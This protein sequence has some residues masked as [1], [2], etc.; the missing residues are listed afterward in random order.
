MFIS[1]I[2]LSTNPPTLYAHLRNMYIN[3]MLVIDFI[4]LW[5]ILKLQKRH[6]VMTIIDM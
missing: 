4:H 5:I 1:F 2:N 6:S 3:K